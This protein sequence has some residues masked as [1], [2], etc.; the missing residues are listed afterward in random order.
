MRRRRSFKRL[1]YYII[2]IILLLLALSNYQ[3]HQPRERFRK[4]LAS[5]PPTLSRQIEQLGDTSADFTDALGL[6]G[7]D[8]SVLSSYKPNTN[9]VFFAGM[10]QRLSRST[11]PNDL[12]ILHKTGFTIAYSPLLKH[13]VWAAYKTFLTPNR[14]LPRDPLD[15]NPTRKH[16]IHPSNKTIPIA[17]M[18]AAT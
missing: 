18:I 16:R 14:T 1:N 10:P 5:L 12:K 17:D 9:S 2:A 13:A 7:H 4:Q 6:T 11:L 8:V 15:L 3:A